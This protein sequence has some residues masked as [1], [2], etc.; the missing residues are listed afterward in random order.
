[1]KWSSHRAITRA[2]LRELGL[3]E[4]TIQTALESVI[5]PDRSQDYV[6]KIGWGGRAY[7]APE[8]HHGVSNSKIIDLLYKARECRLRGEKMMAAHYLGLA[9]HY[10]QDRCVKPGSFLKS[11]EDV[12][13]EVS[14]AG[15]PRE[16]IL[17]GLRDSV[18]HPIEVERAVKSIKQYASGDDAAWEAAYYTAWLSKAVFSPGSFRRAEIELRRG[19]RLTKIFGT[20]SL[21]TAS[22]GLIVTALTHSL[23][24]TLMSLVTLI[25]LI[26][27]LNRVRKIK[28]WFGLE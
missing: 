1:V 17:Q 3:D 6:V 14:E 25:P 2:A 9:L 26:A 4:A 11:H 10:V 22:I 13:W 15:V 18:S 21:A 5:E 7:L 20:L 19:R 16:T 24:P 12:E 28:R 27:A 8:S 23:L